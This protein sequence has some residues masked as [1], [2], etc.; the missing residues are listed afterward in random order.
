MLTVCHHL[1]SSLVVV[2]KFM[3]FSFKKENIFRHIEMVQT[4]VDVLFLCFHILPTYS[5]T[6]TVLARISRI[7]GTAFN[8]FT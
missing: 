4:N 1:Q 6:E 8:S 7:E 3:H 5:T 2:A